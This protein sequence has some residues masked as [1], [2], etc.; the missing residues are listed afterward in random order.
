[1][2]EDRAGA[3]GCPNPSRRALKA[4]VTA[5]RP[6]DDWDDLFARLTPTEIEG[7]RSLVPYMPKKAAQ[8]FAD[9]LRA[10]N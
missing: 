7:L 10:A 2:N 3:E 6:G 8:H 1:M 4:V 9:W 5:F